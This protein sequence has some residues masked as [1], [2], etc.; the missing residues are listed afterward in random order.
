MEFFDKAKAVRLR[1][2]HGKYLVA[3]EDEDTV[4]QSRNGSSQHA[5]WKVEFI[6]G[7]SRRIRLKS[8]YN[9]Y[10][11]ASAE[12]YLLGMMGNKVLQTS[13]NDGWVEWEPIK[14]RLQVKFRTRNE[15]FLRANGGPPPWRNS[16]T[17]GI[18]HRTVTQDWVLWGI[19]VV[20]LLELES[21]SLVTDN[22]KHA[23]G[24]G[25]RFV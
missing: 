8:I 17:N 2:Y 10:L 16:V 23:F 13:Q 11:T 21:P 14:D 7:D 24:R 5:R 19:D 4:R 1:S 18:P 22:S 9:K 6:E 25:A 15:K 3:N 12:P 20:E